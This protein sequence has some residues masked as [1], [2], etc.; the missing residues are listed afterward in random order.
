MIPPFIVM[1]M[2]RSRTAWLSKFLTYKPW[3]C[4]HDQIRY[5]RSLDDIV[6]WFKQP[7]IGTAETGAAPYWRLIQRYAPDA[8]VL[9]VR[10]PVL[11]VMDSVK[12]QGVGGLDYPA[13]L[14]NLIRLDAKLNQAEMRLPNAISINYDE[15]T[16]PGIC[17]I[18]FEH[19][20]GMPFNLQ[21]W[22]YWNAINVQVDFDATIRYVWAHMEQLQRLAFTAR[23]Q[24]MADLISKSPD[25][26]A[27]GLEIKEETFDQSFEDA[28]VLATEHCVLLGQPADEWSR[29]NILMLQKFDAVGML[30]VLTAR[31]NGKMFG[32][33]VS[34]LGETLDSATARSATHTLFFA[35]KEW[36]GA[37]LRL[38]REA[39]A[40]LKAKGFNEV[41]MRTGTATERLETIYKRI[42]ADYDGRIY[43]VRLEP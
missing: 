41:V 22:Q 37:G 14:R 21:W 32:Y 35:S 26:I 38:Q 18:V 39:L 4:G 28:T 29:N 2:P 36:P 24:M 6:C 10:R 5:L 27:D 25:R 31:A 8:R 15:L 19:C 1:G 7:Y 23:H 20:L 11:E 3:V 12:K 13:I 33:L 16:D 34:M 30:Q 40:R 17:R 9:V 42:G 43:R